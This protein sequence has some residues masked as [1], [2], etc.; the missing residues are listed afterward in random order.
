MDPLLPS[1]LLFLLAG[2]FL[3]IAAHLCIFIRGEWHVE[4]PQLVVGH[5]LVFL[6][7]AMC[8]SFLRD[9]VW[10]CPLVD[11]LVLASVAYLPGLFASIFVYRVSPFHRLTAAGFP[12]PFGARVSKLWHVW[13]CRYSKNHEV[14]DRL[15]QEYGDFVRTGEFRRY[16]HCLSVR[17]YQL[18]VVLAMCITPELKRWTLD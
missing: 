17:Y 8:R 9:S 12:G 16:Q 2:G 15:H 6:C 1:H 14:L 4:A 13:A 11:G 3:G 5:A 10:L 7:V 18:N